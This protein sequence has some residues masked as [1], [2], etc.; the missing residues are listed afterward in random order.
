MKFPCT[1]QRAFVIDRLLTRFLRFAAVQY[2]DFADRKTRS[3]LSH[4]Y[5]R[6]NHVATV[7]I[8][9]GLGDIHT[10]FHRCVDSGH[11]AVPH[12]LPLSNHRGRNL[13]EHLNDRSLALEHRF[14]ATDLMS[15]HRG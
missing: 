3:Y 14:N 4:G 1:S 8:R 13:I 7:M 15:E 9:C 10:G 11:A 12:K 5:Y 2:P 6:V